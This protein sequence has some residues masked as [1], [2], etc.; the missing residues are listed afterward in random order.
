MI[1]RIKNAGKNRQLGFRPTV[2]GLAKNA[3]DHPHGGGEG[4]SSP[5]R[6]QR[7]P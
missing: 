7:T 3:C 2:R 1:N 6:A 5:P 4:Q